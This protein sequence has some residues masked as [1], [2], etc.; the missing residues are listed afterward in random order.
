MSSS[1][2][3]R[4]SSGQ[5][6]QRRTQ[7]PPD[8]HR[9]VDSPS[10]LAKFLECHA[11]L[12]PREFDHG[13]DGL[14]VV[15]RGR[16]SLFETHA[17]GDELLL[18]SI[19]DVAFD[20][21]PSRVG[22]CG[23]AL[24]GSSSVFSVGALDCL[25]SG[26]LLEPQTLSDVAERDDG[27]PSVTVAEW[28]G[29]VGHGDE[30]ASLRTNPLLHMEGLSRDPDPKQRALV[31]RERRPVGAEGVDR[32]V[33]GAADELRRFGIAEDPGGGRIEE[34]DEAIAIDDVERVGSGGDDTQERVAVDR[35]GDRRV[36]LIIS[37]APEMDLPRVCASKS[38]RPRATERIQDQA[39]F[40]NRPRAVASSARDVIASLG[41]TWYRW[42]P[43]V[44]CDR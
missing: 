36:R 31:D 1:R 34:A 19:V 24:R 16:P 42:K 28:G 10:Q 17:D 43:I 23:D 9:R 7:P 5:G 35:H 38:G 6:S 37:S 44:R 41:N 26:R 15:P 29:A 2:G 39:V 22:G 21:F 8:E 27:P 11:E 40:A 14:R 33:A 13:G 25:A 20:L 12:A 4:A 3:D 18:G 30:G 32:V